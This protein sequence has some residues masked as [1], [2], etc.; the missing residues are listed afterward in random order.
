MEL[1]LSRMSGHALVYVAGV[2]Q[3]LAVFLIR[4]A[5]VTP[6]WF[7]AHRANPCVRFDVAEGAACRGGEGRG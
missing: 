2:A 3:A 4:Y 7:D 6:S 5:E 1:D